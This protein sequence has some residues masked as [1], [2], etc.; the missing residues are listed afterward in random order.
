[1][2][3]PGNSW[4]RRNRYSRRRV[5]GAS[6]LT[7]AGLAAISLVGCGDD[8]DDDESPTA[9]STSGGP[10]AASSPAAGQPKRGG[11]FLMPQ[12]GDYT[13]DY[14]PHTSLFQSAFIYSYIGNQVIRMGN[15]GKTLQAELAEDWEIP[16]DGSEYLFNVRPGMKWFNRPPTDGRAITADDIAFN[17]ERMAGKFATSPADAA[18]FQRKS[19]LPFFE[20]ATA[21]SES[22]VQVKLSA[23]HSSFLNGLSDT[24]NGVAARD[25]LE[26]SPKFEDLTTHV[27]SGPFIPQSFQS[28][29]RGVFKA[30]PDYW[31]EGR[32]YFDGADWI[33]FA[34]RLS[35]LTAFGQGGVDAFDSPT[36]SERETVKKLAG[37]S[38]IVTS[39]SSNWNFLR[40]NT[41]RPAPFADP[42]VRRALFLALDLKKIGDGWFGD[43]NWSYTGPVA[44]VFAEG[45]PA[46]ELVKLLGYNPGTRDEAI[47]TAKELMTG[48]GYPDGDFAFKILPNLAGG[49]SSIHAQSAIRYVDHIKK[50]WP[51]M[52]VEIDPLTD[53][54]AFGARQVQGD[55]DAIAYNILPPPDG[56]LDTIGQYHSNGSRNYQKFADSEVDGLLEKAIT[57]LDADDRTE[58]LRQVERILIEDKL[59]MAHLS[60]AVATFYTNPK[61]KG[62]DGTGVDA[63]MGLNSSFDFRYS[64]R[65]MWKES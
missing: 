64:V 23:P 32:P 4:V 33:W 55:F 15:D 10:T 20:S 59:S 52:Q 28:G 45:M 16:G 12:V 63:A 47:K 35:M 58:T 1:M 13:G 21:V 26:S 14:D 43:G 54:T 11:T 57:Q 49:P 18:R 38:T 27:A 50:V 65:K 3:R 25:W 48:A 37:D 61:V 29:T 60:H 34:D 44:A 62:V 51:D 24:R 17:I 19:S 41:K 2:T 42:K 40:F 5:L 31:E 30:N 22:V 8:D 9:A 46:S 36:L 39:V 56:L 6:G 7:A 53:A